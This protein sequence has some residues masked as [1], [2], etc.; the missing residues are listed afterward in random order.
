MR[1]RAELARVFLRLQNPNVGPD[2]ARELRK[3][4]ANSESEIAKLEDA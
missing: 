1:K 3:H 2:L 4:I